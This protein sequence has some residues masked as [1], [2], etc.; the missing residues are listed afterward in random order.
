MG[1]QDVIEIIIL[2][3]RRVIGPLFIERPFSSDKAQQLS[4]EKLSNIIIVVKNLTDFLPK[5]TKCLSGEGKKIELLA[6]RLLQALNFYLVL[7]KSFC[8]NFDL[9]KLKAECMSKESAA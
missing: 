6:N 9:E 4:P 1:S 8:L 3:L 7:N 5:L 2:Q